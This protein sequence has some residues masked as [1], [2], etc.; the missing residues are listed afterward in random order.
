VRTPYIVRRGIQVSRWRAGLSAQVPRTADGNGKLRLCRR[1]RDSLRLSACAKDCRGKRRVLSRARRRIGRRRATAPAQRGT[2]APPSPAVYPLTPVRNEPR[3]GTASAPRVISA[4][5]PAAQAAP[6][7]AAAATKP[8][9]A[10]SPSN[11]SVSSSAAGETACPTTNLAT[12]PLSERAWPTLTNDCGPPQ[13]GSWAAS[14]D[15]LQGEHANSAER[16][17]KPTN[18]GRIAR[19]DHCGLELKSGSNNEGVDGVG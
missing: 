2:T 7:P 18:V 8:H 12:S 6:E 10:R 17:S 16:R 13:G 3:A 9:C 14:P 15:W 11:G 1:I 5:P 19:G 4:P